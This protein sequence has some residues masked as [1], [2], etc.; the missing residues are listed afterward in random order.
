MRLRDF[1]KS[2]IRHP[3][4]I[5]FFKYFQNTVQTFMHCARTYRAVLE[6]RGEILRILPTEHE[7][8][9]PY[10]T[11]VLRNLAAGYFEYSKPFWDMT[12]TR[13]AMNLLHIL[14]P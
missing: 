8:L 5:I 4:L 9:I 11:G 1:Q 7:K 3:Q 13:I 2:S 10:L 12:Q 6:L 14:H